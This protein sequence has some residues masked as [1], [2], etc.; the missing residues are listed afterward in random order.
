MHPIAFT[1]PALLKALCIFADA[2]DHL[3]DPRD[4]RGVRYPLAVLL[5][6]LLVA[7]AGGG[8]T[9]AAVAEFTVDHQAWFRLWLPLGRSVPTDDTY[10]LL[11]RR[12]DP[13]TAMQASLLLLDGSSLPGLQELILALDGK[14][15]RRSGDR[16]AGTRA[17][18]LV[19]AFLVR[20]GLTLAQEPCEAKS[21]EITAMPRLLARMVLEGA[22]V[23]I[24]AA[25]CQ[26]AIVQALRAA[27]A[28]YVLAVKRNQPS[29][30][31]EVR[32]AF[33]D[34][35]RGAFAP[36][37]QDGCET[38]ERNGGRR[39]R[40]TCTVLGGPGLCEWVADPEAWPGLH[41]LIRA[42]L[43]RE[44]A[45]GRRGPAGA[46]PRP[47]GHRERPA[48][49]PGRAVPRGRLPPAPG[50]RPRRDGHLQ[51]GCPE[52]GAHASA[53]FQTGF[54]HWPAAGQDR[55]QPRPAGPDPGLN[56]TFR[57]P[58]V[59]IGMAADGW[60]YRDK[61]ELTT[62]AVPYFLAQHFRPNQQYD[63]A[64]VPFLERLTRHQTDGRLEMRVRHPRGKLHAKLYIWTDADGR[65]EAMIGSSNLTGPGLGGQG[66]LNAYMRKSDSTRYFVAWFD[67]RWQEKD[68]VGGPKLVEDA[69][70]VVASN[71][72]DRRGRTRS[73]HSGR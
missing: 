29:L 68:S 63:Q 41:S 71:R 15:A 65:Q 22:V 30:H 13:E 60:D 62:R 52:H 34:A 66:E 4:P 49:H 5:G 70:K 46:G 24:D 40:R 48:P 14:V 7:V 59:L 57:L 51:T 73:S 61:D 23:T 69:Q 2:R 67:A 20:E 8:D 6:T 10:R 17:Q 47:L 35:D 26:R 28:D 56:A 72:P 44:P 18:F 36:E 37:V 16:A 43:H 21:N 42:L 11:V 12:L 25:G 27:G 32:A 3:P 9:L 45:C 31:A 1:A 64:T 53:E 33:E 39:E 50:A 58:W 38:V 19:S 54:V 55:A